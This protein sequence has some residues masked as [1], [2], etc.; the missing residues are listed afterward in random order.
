MTFRPRAGGP[1]RAAAGEMTLDLWRPGD[2]STQEA[3]CQ[4]AKLNTHTLLESVLSTFGS[5]NYPNYCK[6]SDFRHPCF[7]GGRGVIANSPPPVSPLTRESFVVKTRMLATPEP[8]IDTNVPNVVSL[9]SQLCY[10][11]NRAAPQRL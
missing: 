10:F 11:A 3:D 4:S 5:Q 7:T 8:T 2:G 9:L 6:S 1:L